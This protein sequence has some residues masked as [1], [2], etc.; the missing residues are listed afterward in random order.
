MW[1]YGGSGFWGEKD[2]AYERIIAVLDYKPFIL[3]TEG[4]EN[5]V[6]NGNIEFKGV[7]FEYTNNDGVL[8]SISAKYTKI[9]EEREKIKLKKGLLGFFK[10]DETELEE[11]TKK[12][13]AEKNI[14]KARRK[15]NV[16][17]GINMKID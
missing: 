8:D 7:S 11:E 9:K 15:K 10:V 4:I 2:I 12:K 17:K 3:I 13:E 16:L 14:E 5:H 6:L 1:G